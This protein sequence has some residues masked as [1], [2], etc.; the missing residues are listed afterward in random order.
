MEHSQPCPCCASDARVSSA[1]DP[2]PARPPSRSPRELQTCPNRPPLLTPLRIRKTV[3]FVK[4]APAER[5]EFPKRRMCCDWYLGIYALGAEIRTVDVGSG[6]VGADNS[7]VGSDWKDRCNR[8]L[9]HLGPQLE[10]WDRQH[11]NSCI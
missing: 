9:G 7:A 4:L 10:S 8:R 1:N 5:R 2:S 3:K 11:C 6:A